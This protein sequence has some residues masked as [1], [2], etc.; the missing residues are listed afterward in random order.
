MHDQCTT[1]RSGAE[2]RGTFRFSSDERK[3]RACAQDSARTA[4]WS[5][6][7]APRQTPASCNCECFGSFGESPSMHFEC[8]GSIEASPSNHFGRTGSTGAS[9][10][11]HFQS[12]VALVK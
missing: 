3:L 11:S 12:Q 6:L 2:F 4:I 10:S 7:A 5:I 8:S 1:E 9:P